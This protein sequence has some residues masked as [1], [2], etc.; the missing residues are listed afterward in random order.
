MV[1]FWSK[2]KKN[3][4]KSKLNYTEPELWKTMPMFKILQTRPGLSQLITN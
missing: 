1:N 3:Y 4:I 2:T